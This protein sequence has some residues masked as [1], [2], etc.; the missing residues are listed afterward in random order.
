M[1]KFDENAIDRLNEIARQG[2][3]VVKPGELRDYLTDSA[4]NNEMN[5]SEYI[6]KYTQSIRGFDL[7]NGIPVVIS[8]DN[9]VDDIEPLGAMPTRELFTDRVEADKLIADVPL[10]NV[11]V[12]GKELY[13]N[14][15]GFHW[16]DGEGLWQ[17]MS[18]EL[19]D[20]VPDGDEDRLIEWQNLPDDDLE[21]LLQCAKEAG[22]I[23]DYEIEDEN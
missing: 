9:G 21:T 15:D 3:W 22:F 20:L 7:N 23:K 12:D 18:E 6:D 19:T 1:Q 14:D 11:T 17:A 2:V 16:L 4:E 13:N 8:D 5:L 10:Y